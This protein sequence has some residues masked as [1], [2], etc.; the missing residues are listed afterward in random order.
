[1]KLAPI[2]EVI[3]FKIYLKKSSGIITVADQGQDTLKK[4]QIEKAEVFAVGNKVESVK[5]GDRVD[6]VNR[7]FL[8]IDVETLLGEEVDEYI[9]YV[10]GKEEDIN[11]VIAD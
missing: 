2:N 7:T 4:W 1:M 6:I 9:S 8:R 5:A 11:F 3:I 10:R